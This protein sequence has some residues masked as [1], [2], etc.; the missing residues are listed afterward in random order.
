MCFIVAQT[1]KLGEHGLNNQESMHGRWECN[2]NSKKSTWVHMKEFHFYI[3]MK[4][5]PFDLDE[6][7]MR[8]DRKYVFHNQDEK[9][10][11][12][13]SMNEKSWKLSVKMVLCVRIM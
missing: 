8:F 11:S 2:Q 12:C 3:T 9:L 6:Y 10:V 1:L 7:F 5:V 4:Q 13:S